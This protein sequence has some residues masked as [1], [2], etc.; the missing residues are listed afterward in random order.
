MCG[1]HAGHLVKP[2]SHRQL[3]KE[4]SGEPTQNQEPDDDRLSQM[5]TLLCD[6]GQGVSSRV[7]S[8]EL[9][10]PALA[11]LCRPHQQSGNGMPC[12]QRKKEDGQ[13]S[14]RLREGSRIDKTMRRA[15]WP[16]P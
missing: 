10:E 5:Q 7:P 13:L 12:V 4:I 8:Y 15:F 9:Q 16:V 3:G 2:L 14:Q 11:R 1:N 6:L